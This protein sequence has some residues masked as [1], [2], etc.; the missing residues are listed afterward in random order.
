MGIKISELESASS[1]N[2]ED[3]FPIV[4]GNKTKKLAKEI[5]LGSIETQVATN[6]QDIS[7]IK[8]EQITQNNK[9]AENERNI[10]SLQVNKADKTE[11]PT[12]L[13]QLSNADTKFVNE[14]QMANAVQEELIARQNADVNLQGQIDAITSQSDV[15]DV[16]GTYADLLGYDTSKITENDIVK[17]LN[18]N[19]H[20]NATSYFRWNNNT[21]NYVGSEGPN[22][23]KSETDTLLNQKA[24]QSSL[25]ETNQRVNQKA[26]QSSLDTTNQNLNTLA[27]RVTTNENDISNIKT[28][29]NTQ[30][31]QIATLILDSANKIEL[32]VN[33][34]TYILTATLKNKAGEILNSSQVDLPLEAMIV[35]ATYDSTTKELVLT[36]QNG[37]TIRVS[38][39]DIVSGLVSQTD[40]NAL[41]IRVQ[42]AEGDITDIKAEQITQNTNIT[43]LQNRVTI[44]ENTVDSELEDG[45]ATGESITV[46][47][48]ANAP[49]KIGVSG[50]T[51]QTQYEG[52]NLAPNNEVN[53]LTGYAN[54]CSPSSTGEK[55]KW[56][57]NVNN[58][59]KDTTII[60]SWE[61]T[62]DGE[63]VENVTGVMVTIRYTDSSTQSTYKGTS[64]IIPSSKTIQD[65]VVYGGEGTT[66]NKWANIQYELGSTVT[67]Y[68]PFVGGQ[69][70]PNPDYPQQIHVVKGRNEFLIK[71][72]NLFNSEN[73]YE[74]LH[75]IY[76]TSMTKEIVN[77]I[78]YYKFKP[79]GLNEYIYMEGQFK[80]NIQ[81]R[82]IFKGKNYANRTD[83]STGFRFLYTDG[84]SSARWITTA[85]E[86]EYELISDAGK[87]I[88]GFVVPYNLNEFVLV[89]DILLTEGTSKIPYFP[90]QE[91]RP[92]FTLEE[93]QNMYEGGYLADNGIHNVRKQLV[94]DGTENWAQ[95]SSAKVFYL[96]LPNRTYSKSPKKG[97]ISNYFIGIPYKTGLSGINK[98]EITLFSSGSAINLAL[99]ELYI[100][101][102]TTATVEQFKQFLADKYASRN[103]VIVEF[104]AY[105][106]IIEPYTQTQQA[107]YNALQNVLSYYG[108]TNVDTITAEDL[109]PM[110]TLDYKKS[111]RL[112]IEN[113]E[114]RLD[115]LEG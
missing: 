112:R 12:N 5:L 68:E 104:D 80:E 23:T 32:S 113:I 37:N 13:N 31:T 4:Q 110:L 46:N 76:E 85:T 101:Y 86:T 99:C 103:P 1:V 41:E 20:D 66:T 78:L 25:D 59:P 79:V 73:W 75:N 15:V 95:G 3:V 62:G 47:D 90:Y 98:G 57:E 89:R 27:G 74:T 35:N 2:N 38:I 19:T 94:L 64:F 7:D 9:I 14:T 33:S 91:Q 72:G 102:D 93:G 88:R 70:S 22:Y 49:A 16:V 83:A 55:K 44:L 8:G 42:T 63:P 40:F 71:N 52:K 111:N 65:I 6:T 69:P 43:A 106:E 17:V 58:L 107:Q 11:I 51:E 87:T 77:N 34:Q 28:E 100:N 67:T 45:T 26:N 21:W 97:C 60:G 48:S 108:Q 114:S 10:S 92:E 30:N 84:T 54:S 109:K 36:L 105:E 96:S 29:Q 39:A 61:Y 18:D 24:N 50:Q 81:Y 115:L 53:N 56:W 82:L